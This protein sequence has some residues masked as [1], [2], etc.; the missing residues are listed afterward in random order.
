MDSGLPSHLLPIMSYLHLTWEQGGG[1]GF[2]LGLG[3]TS[4][5]HPASAQ[6][7]AHCIRVYNSTHATGHA[8]K[9]VGGS[10]I[11]AL[12]PANVKWVLHM[13][14]HVLNFAL[15][16]Q[17]AWS[18]HVLTSVTVG[19][20]VQSVL[21]YVQVLCE[22][23]L[24]LCADILSCKPA[25]CHYSW[26]QRISKH[27]HQYVSLLPSSSDASVCTTSIVWPDLN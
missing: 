11:K 5:S 20:G 21:M 4:L 12:L 3:A 1:C 13:R 17:T 15:M 16:L 23:S 26:L 25:K 10:I 19:L 8:Q 2:A 18:R 14:N 24:A 22:L 6:H 27:S 7:T 9:E